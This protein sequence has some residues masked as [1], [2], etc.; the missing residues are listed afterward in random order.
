MGFIF[1]SVWAHGGVVG[2]LSFPGDYA[3]FDE[4]LPGAGSGAVDAMGGADYFVVAPAVAVEDVAATSTFAEY[5]ASVVAFLPFGKVFS[6][7]EEFFGEGTVWAGLC[8]AGGAL[9]CC[10]SHSFSLTNFRYEKY[11]IKM[12][13]N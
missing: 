7:F 5:G 8:G 1:G 11:Q 10:F 4:D 13:A 3:V 12:F 9:G 2:S 6:E